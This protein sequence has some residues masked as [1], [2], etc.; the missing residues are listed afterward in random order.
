SGRRR[1]L[2]RV[3]LGFGYG[4]R[5][6]RPAM[7]RLWRRCRRG[8]DRRT[9]A[10]CADIVLWTDQTGSGTDD[11]D[12]RQDAW[13]RCNR[14][15]VSERLRPWPEPFKPVHRHIGD[16]LEFD[17]AEKIHQRIR[18]WQG[19]PRLRLYRRRHRCDRGLHALRRA[20]GACGEYRLGRG[21]QRAHRR[22]IDRGLFW[23][24]RTRDNNRRFSPGRHT[25][26]FRGHREGGLPHEIPSEMVV[27]RRPSFLFELGR[28]E[29]TDRGGLRPVAARTQR[30]RTDG[31]GRIVMTETVEP[32]P[33]HRPRF[34]AR[35]AITPQ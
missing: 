19:N 33:R 25:A 4:G 17:Q 30:T 18:G 10:L 12:L 5:T 28:I 23:R 21:N 35:G 14:S 24:R 13:S 31:I 9:S 27:P 6:F 15:A 7:S 1:R 34:A 22:E 16:L 20:W 2:S 26:Q 32:I 8:T 11:V 3:S 29:R